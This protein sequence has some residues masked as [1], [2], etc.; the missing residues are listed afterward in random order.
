MATLKAA[1]TTMSHHSGMTGFFSGPYGLRYTMTPRPIRTTGSPWAARH[2]ITGLWVL[3]RKIRVSPRIAYPSRIATPSFQS[4]DQ[5]VHRMM[6]LETTNAAG[7]ITE[8]A[9]SRQGRSAF[10]NRR[11]KTPSDSG[12]PAYISTLALVI[13]PTS[14]CQLGNG[15]K[16]MQPTMN[17]VITPT[18]GPRA[19]LSRSNHTGKYPLRLSP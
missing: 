11:R 12:A 5:P 15:R 17:D 18:Q 19:S 10:G 13:R 1:V 6:R 16:Q 4:V 9:G 8:A 14:D 3:S 7:E 2:C